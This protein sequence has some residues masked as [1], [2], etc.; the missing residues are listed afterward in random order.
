MQDLDRIV[1]VDL[2]IVVNVFERL[3]LDRQVF[4]RERMNSRRQYL[5]GGVIVHSFIELQSS[6]NIQ[7]LLAS[8]L[9]SPPAN[10]RDH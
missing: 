10:H 7:L 1:F 2:R 5:Q 9:N 8:L 6:L 3:L 4:V